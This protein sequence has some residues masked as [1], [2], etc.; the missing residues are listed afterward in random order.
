M[1]KVPKNQV[2]QSDLIESH[3]SKP[4]ISTADPHPVIVKFVKIWKKRRSLGPKKLVENL[5]E[6]NQR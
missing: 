5:S 4:Y 2:N 1:Q 6:Q 3:F